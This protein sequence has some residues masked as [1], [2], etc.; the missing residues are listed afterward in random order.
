MS[1][2]HRCPVCHIFL[3]QDIYWGQIFCGYDKKLL[4]HSGHMLPHY[5]YH[6][7]PVY[8]PLN[9]GKYDLNT[10]V[11]EFI[12]LEP[13][14]ILQ[15][16]LCTRIVKYT[17]TGWEPVSTHPKMLNGCAIKMVKNNIMSLQVP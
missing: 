15:N 8:Y 7:R 16:D 11:T 13:Y 3:Q 1:L 6:K 14:R 9:Y 4:V 17:G 5:V 10:I 12:Y 2:P